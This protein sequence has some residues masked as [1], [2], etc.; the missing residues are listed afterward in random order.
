[1]WGLGRLRVWGM[2]F[3]VESFGFSVEGGGVEV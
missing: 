2:K 1:M 3:S